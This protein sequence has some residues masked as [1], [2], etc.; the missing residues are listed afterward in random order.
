MSRRASYPGRV[1]LELVGLLPWRRRRLERAGVVP[2]L[3]DALASDRRIDLY[4]ILELVESSCASALAA[5]IVAPL[6][7]PA[8]MLWRR[9]S[10]CHDVHGTKY[11]FEGTVGSGHKMITVAEKETI[12][13]FLNSIKV[14]YSNSKIPLPSGLVCRGADSIRDAP[15]PVA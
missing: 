6:D 8:V 5:R 4:A 9:R 3:A 14:N 15:A 7:G 2:A 13:D 11:T 12:Y 10:S 1:D